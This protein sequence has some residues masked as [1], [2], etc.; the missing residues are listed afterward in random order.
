MR[1]VDTLILLLAVLLFLAVGVWQLIVTLRRL[2]TWPTAVGTVVD[3]TLDVSDSNGLKA[4][5]VE[6]RTPDGHVVRA[7]DRAKVF[8]TRHRLGKE[9]TVRYDARNPQ[10]VTVGYL[11]LVVWPILIVWMLGGLWFVWNL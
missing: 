4:P 6:F 3:Y 1:A 2:L 8:W 7:S 9:V 10:R 5:I 11:L